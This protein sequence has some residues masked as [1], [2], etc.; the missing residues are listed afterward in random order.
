MLFRSSDSVAWHSDNEH[1]LGPEPVIA[2]VSLGATRR[3]DFRHRETGETVRSE[4][5]SGDVVIM[6]GLSQACWLHQVPKTKK[7][8]GQRVNLTFRVIHV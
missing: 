1:E 5:R 3:F 7:A 2:S 8:V 6:S 4:L